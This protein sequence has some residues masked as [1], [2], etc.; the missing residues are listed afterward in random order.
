MTTCAKCGREEKDDEAVFCQGCG[1]RFDA[2]EGERGGEDAPKAKKKK[3]RKGSASKPLAPGAF[4]ARCRDESS[5]DAAG[6]VSTSAG[7]GRK[8]YGEADPCAECGSV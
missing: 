6:D 8:F 2:A 7:M 1:A 5:D 4:C 3:K